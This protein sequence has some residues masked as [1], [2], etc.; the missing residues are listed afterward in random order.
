MI[1]ELFI[2]YELIIILTLVRSHKLL[3]RTYTTVALEVVIRAVVEVV[4][5]VKLNYCIPIFNRNMVS[6]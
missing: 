2:A 5:L 6:T 3:T 1:L 4:F